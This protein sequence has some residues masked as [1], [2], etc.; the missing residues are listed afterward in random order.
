MIKLI[1]RDGDTNNSII[2]IHRV[3]EI[4]SVRLNETN[5]MPSFEIWHSEKGHPIDPNDYKS[6]LNITAI[7]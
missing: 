1:S 5:Y 3:D 4:P 7:H 6:I 2:N